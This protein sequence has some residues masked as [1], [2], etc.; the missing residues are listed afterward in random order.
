MGNYL[1][2]Y[3]EWLNVKLQFV[4]SS[5]EQRSWRQTEKGHLAWRHKLFYI[6]YQKWILIFPSLPPGLL[7][8]LT[9]FSS[10]E[11]SMCAP[12]IPPELFALTPASRL[13]GSASESVFLCPV[14]CVSCNTLTCVSDPNLAGVM[15]W[16]RPLSWHADEAH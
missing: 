15:C 3:N 12:I 5:W 4:L 11:D 13:P 1:R 8:P 16:C 7:V 10:C 9:V 14:S 2:T 6:A